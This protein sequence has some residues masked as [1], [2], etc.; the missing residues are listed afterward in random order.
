MAQ[1][2]PAEQINFVLF[3]LCWLLSSWFNMEEGY[4]HCGRNDTLASFDSD[5]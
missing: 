1:A 5:K 3:L 2:Q 4:G